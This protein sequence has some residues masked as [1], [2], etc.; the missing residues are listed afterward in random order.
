MTTPSV[1][2]LRA[3]GT[4]CEAETA[5]AFERFG[6]RSETVHVNRLLDAPDLLSRHHLLAVPGG[7]AYGDDAGAGAVLACE[8]GSVLAEP[9]ERF[10]ADGGLVLGICN[11]FQALV[12]LGLLPGLERPLGEQE[13]SLTDNDSHKYEDRWVRLS[14]TSRRC[15]FVGDMEPPELPLA[16]GEGKIVCRDADVRRRLVDD[17]RVVFRYCDADGQPTQQ[18]PENP[19]GSE[20][21][22]AGLTDRTGRVLGLMPHPERAL[23]G[24]HH[25]DWT[26]T[27][28]AAGGTPPDLGPGAPLFAN[29]CE[30]VRTHR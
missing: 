17:D 22:I 8:M 9:L 19:N 15:I 12:R 21:A 5:Y 7:F 3:A 20:D 30:W 29:A 2:V 11:G 26:R 6:A 13:V 18:Y 14:I 16:H 28:R 24:F 4:N 25:P 1:L 10:V 23:F 27:S